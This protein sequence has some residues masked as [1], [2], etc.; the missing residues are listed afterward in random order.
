[1]ATRGR[2][3][4]P[5]TVKKL[6]GN[7]GKRALK[8]PAKSSEKAVKPPP[9]ADESATSGTTPVLKMPAGLPAAAQRE[10]KRVVPFLEKAG[11]VNGYDQAALADYCLC[12]HRLAE[13]EA[14]VTKRGV[15]VEGERGKVKN[16]A[17][18]LAREYRNS[19]RQWCS[20]FGLTPSSRGRMNI[21]EPETEDEFEKFLNGGGEDDEDE[22]G[23]SFGDDEEEED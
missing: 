21:P 3:P 20:E 7:P 23:G 13:C 11:V 2:K 6:Q 4:K 12:V 22:D 8:P 14:D 5:D 19:I 10:W 16:P 1:M 9:K 18:Q 17:L 15:L